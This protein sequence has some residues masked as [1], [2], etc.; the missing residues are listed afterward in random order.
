MVQFNE[1]PSDTLV[2]FT[3]V[4]ISAQDAAASAGGFRAVLIGQRLAAGTVAAETPTPVGDARDA[5][6]KFGAGSQLAIMCE[7]FRRQNARG[8]LWA[9]AL[10]DAA[11]STDQTITVTVTSAATGAGTI[12]LYIAGRRLP[13]NVS[14]AMTTAQ[15]ATAINTAVENAGGG[16]VG[17]LPVSTGVSGSVVTLTA[18]NAGTS[19]DIDVRDSYQPDESLPPGVALTIASTAGATDPDITGATDAIEDDVFNVIGHP[20][21]VAAT[22]D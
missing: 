18:R 2:P 20:Y 6:S 17:I 3:Y 13:V 11:G 22:M 1:V 8:R 7:A 19:M 12:A 9:V 4:E 14:G 15:I 5:R 10:D 21:S 16:T